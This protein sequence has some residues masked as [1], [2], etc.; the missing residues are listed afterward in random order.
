[1]LDCQMAISNERTTKCH[2]RRP[3]PKR[4]LYCHLGGAANMMTFSNALYQITASL[5]GHWRA[6]TPVNSHNDSSLCQSISRCLSILTTHDHHAI[7]TR[8][9]VSKFVQRLI[10]HVTHRP[11][12]S[13]YVSTFHTTRPRIQD[14]NKRVLLKHEV[15]ARQAKWCLWC[16]WNWFFWWFNYLMEPSTTIPLWTPICP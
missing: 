6:V 3:F 10:R 9:N 14:Q 8:S 2:Q 13:V 5:I 16:F 11:R 1:M 4:Y 15:E 7:F 12:R